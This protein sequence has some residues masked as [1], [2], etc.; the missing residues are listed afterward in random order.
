MGLGW[1]PIYEMENNIAMF[2]TTN[3][4]CLEIFQNPNEPLDNGH[5]C[6]KLFLG[7]WNKRGPKQNLGMS[8]VVAPINMAS[9]LDKIHFREH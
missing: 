1:H 6:L 4:P 2:Q 9:R 3:Q 7:F 8:N 5:P